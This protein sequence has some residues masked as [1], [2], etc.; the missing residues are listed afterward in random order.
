MYAYLKPFSLR[1]KRR[2]CLPHQIGRQPQR[3]HILPLSASKQ[4]LSV[5]CRCMESPIKVNSTHD[6]EIPKRFFS[7]RGSHHPLVF[8]LQKFKIPEIPTVI[9]P[10][11]ADM[12]RDG[13]SLRIDN[14]KPYR[15]SSG[16]LPRVRVG[17]HIAMAFPPRA[18]QRIG[19]HVFQTRLSVRNIGFEHPPAISAIE[20]GI[21]HPRIVEQIGNFTCR[22]Q[23]ARSGKPSDK[24]SPE[25]LSDTEATEWPASAA[26]AAFS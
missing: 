3:R 19:K 10:S 9:R 16:K 20:S 21:K 25:R 17:G 14:P 12:R 24:K 6:I 5:D 15:H 26:R 2:I 8:F 22:N 7:H 11:A 18:I 1:R 4:A 13:K 23:S